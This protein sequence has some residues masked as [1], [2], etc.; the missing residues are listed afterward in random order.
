MWSS[1]ICSG[2]I[3]LSMPFRYIKW[4]WWLI[5]SPENYDGRFEYIWSL[6]YFHAICK[7]NQCPFSSTIQRLVSAN[8]VNLGFSRKFSEGSIYLQLQTMISQFLWLK[9]AALLVSVTPLHDCAGLISTVS[10]AFWCP[11]LPV[12]PEKIFRKLN[13]RWFYCPLLCYKQYNGSCYACLMI[14]QCVL[15]FS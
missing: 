15:L 8:F 14:Y 6:S 2:Y 13:C 11:P 10:Q 4:K 3:F 7:E 5:S 1:F 9:I 12:L